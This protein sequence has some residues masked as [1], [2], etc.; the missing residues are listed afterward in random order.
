MNFGPLFTL[1]IVIFAAVSLVERMKPT[2]R[3]CFRY[4]RK[5][6]LNGSIFYRMALLGIIVRCIIPI[7]PPVI[8]PFTTNVASAAMNFASI[9]FIF[10][11]LIS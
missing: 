2:P 7:F 8:F 5:L 4:I 1:F 3:N 9:M 10:D 11:W 6:Y